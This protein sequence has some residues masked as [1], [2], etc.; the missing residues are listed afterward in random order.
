MAVGG[1]PTPE[2]W[3]KMSRG[4]KIA[5]WV[6]VAIVCGILASLAIKKFFF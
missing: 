3:E 5:Y 1:G 6:S 2:Q 4:Q